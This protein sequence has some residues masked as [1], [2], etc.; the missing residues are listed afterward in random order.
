MLVDKLA[1]DPELGPRFAAAR[2]IERP[3][4]LGPMAIDAS[5]AGVP[6]LLLAG[7]AAGFI[8]PMTG[9]GLRF[10][11]TGGL[12]VAAIATDVLA[13]RLPITCAAQRLTEQRRAAFGMKWRFNRTLRALVASPRA[14][15]TAAA[16]ATLLPAAFKAIIR[17]AGDT[18]YRSP[19]ARHNALS[20]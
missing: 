20:V 1:A 2:L 14:V 13:G 6:G 3:T 10:A 16:A 18:N 15:T 7:D 12:L 19:R 8:D 11:L 5:A 4:I 9:D 17:Y